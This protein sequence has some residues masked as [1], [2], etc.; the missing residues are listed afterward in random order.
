MINFFINKS[1]TININTCY[2]IKNGLFSLS[3]NKY[4]KEQESIPISK[5]QIKKS[6]IKVDQTAKFKKIL[7]LTFFILGGALHTT[8][9]R[10]QKDN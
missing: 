1:I 10:Q 4:L 3:L 7:S 8:K 5:Y 2:T 9:N 6:T